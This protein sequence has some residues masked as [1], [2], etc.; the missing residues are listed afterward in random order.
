MQRPIPI[1]F[2]AGATTHAAL[3]RAGELSDGWFPL[4]APGPQLD[5]ALAEIKAAALEAGRDPEAIGM[6]GTLSAGDGDLDH[7]A[8][9]TGAWREKGATHL[10]I[11]TMRA[12]FTRLD[13]HLAALS[14]AAEVSLVPSSP[15]RRPYRIASKRARLDEASLGAIR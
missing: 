13:D 12:G 4:I 9:L 1:W 8:E 15:T 2:G 14:A 3:R 5:E 11:N 10:S 6:E 7:L